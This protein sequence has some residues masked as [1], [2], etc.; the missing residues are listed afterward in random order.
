MTIHDEDVGTLGWSQEAD[1]R[2]RYS[3]KPSEA[4]RLARITVWMMFAAIVL[5][6]V[7]YG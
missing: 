1:G 2:R 3:P 4:M 6:L 5:L 7:L